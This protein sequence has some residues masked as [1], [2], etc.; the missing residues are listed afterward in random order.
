MKTASSTN[1]RIHCDPNKASVDDLDACQS[2]LQMIDDQLVDLEAARE[3]LREMRDRWSAR[4]KAVERREVSPRV[5]RR[6]TKGTIKQAVLAEL[7]ASNSGLSLAEIGTRLGSTIPG[8]NRRSISV[9]LSRLRTSGQ[10]Q[11]AEGRWL[12]TK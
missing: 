11:L 4:L 8:V 2:M 7:G 5:S 3:T 10:I 9:T 1:F 6:A 12:L